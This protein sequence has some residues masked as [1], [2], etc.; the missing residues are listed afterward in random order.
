[1]TDNGHL[2]AVRMRID[3]HEEAV[4]YMRRDCAVCQAEGFTA[5]S[6][7]KVRTNGKSV[8][9]TLNIVGEAV[10]PEG[11]VGL[12]ESAWRYLG[13][14][15]GQRVTV[16]H[17]PV[18]RSLRL[19]RKKIHGN[20]LEPVELDAIIRDI[21]KHLYSDIEIASFL[22]ACAGGRLTLGE[23]I[24]LTRSMVDVG[25]RLHW[26]HAERVFDKHCVGGLPG[27]RTTPIVIAIAS[28]AGLVIPKTSSRAITSPAG[29][30]DTMEVLT[31]VDLTMPQMQAVVQKVGA[32]LAWGGKVRLSPTDD[33]LIRIEKALDLDSDGQLVA[34][35]LSKKI[36]AG[37]THVLIDMPVGPTAKIR[38][39]DHAERLT[40]LFEAVADALD[41]AVRCV[42]TDGTQAVG[43]G[44]GP[45]EEARD[46]LAVL[47]NAPEAPQDLAERSIHLAANLIVM[48]RDNGL[49][50]AVAEARRLLESGAAWQ[51]FERI[52]V[53]QGGLKSLP[54][55][56]Q[57]AELLAAQDGQLLSMDNRRLA[58]LAKLAGA[59]SAPVA[60][61]RLATRVGEPVAAGQLLATLF[62]AT[63]GELAYA[64]AYYDDNADLF[65]VGH[66]GQA[67]E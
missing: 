38:D 53:A 64:R 63:P 66:P 60:G 20:E 29:T 41:I 43:R 54:E 33:L 65:N 39:A 32:C 1:M 27:N 2:H 67:G 24:A 51:Q 6:R 28:A 22:T 42:V 49:E 36:A 11:G 15:E 46:V 55:A 30:A 62:A 25:S 61:L 26:R 9:A 34:S 37:S 23:V 10:L 17:A 13:P 3:T 35:V 14:D 8:I 50:S 44:I 56:P 21:S 40:R 16:R 18:V 31:E 58:Q 59:P 19:L 52:C 4:V 45:V 7:L 57:R 47:R 48:A 5:N 12:S